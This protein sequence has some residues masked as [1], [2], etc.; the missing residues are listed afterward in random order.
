MPNSLS[1]PLPLLYSFLLV[2]ARISG[3]M[4][5]VPIPGATSAPQPVRVVL[6]LAVTLSLFPVWPT[7]TVVPGVGLLTGWLLGEAALGIVIGLL[8]GFIAEAFVLFGQ[9]V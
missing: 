1:L 6:S 9:M 8:V 4:V 7:V 2:L 3:A 5:F